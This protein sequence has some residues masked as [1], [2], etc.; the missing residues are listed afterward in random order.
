MK[1]NVVSILL[2]IPTLILA[3]DKAQFT[4]IPSYR[5]GSPN[6]FQ[7]NIQ[8][9]LEVDS[10]RVESIKNNFKKIFSLFKQIKVIIDIR[11]AQKYSVEKSKGSSGKYDKL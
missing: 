3:L 6:Y 11:E 1:R 10:D 5:I 8:K 4:P 9:S 7:E 2:I